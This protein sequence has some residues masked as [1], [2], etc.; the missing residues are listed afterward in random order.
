M[1]EY[2][3]NSCV[4]LCCH[5]LCCAVLCCA[6]LCCA[7]LCCA[8]LCCVLCCA[9]LCFAVL[10]CV[11]LKVLTQKCAKSA[12][13]RSASKHLPHLQVHLRQRQRMVSRSYL[14]VDAELV[15]LERS[16][17][18]HPYHQLLLGA[19]EVAEVELQMATGEVIHGPLCVHV[20]SG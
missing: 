15:G 17:K 16:D 20:E 18:G 3:I 7:V 4:V 9:V 19:G 13:A 5:V 11:V 8:V 12:N 6:V 1:N 2:K 10:C 14:E